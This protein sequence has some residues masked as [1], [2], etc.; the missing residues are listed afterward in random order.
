VLYC[1]L[2]HLFPY[3]NRLL[4]IL[5]YQPGPVSPSSQAQGS[6]SDNAD[7]IDPSAL[8]RQKQYILFYLLLDVEHLAD[9][10]S[11]ADVAN[12]FGAHFGVPISVQ[13]VL[14]S[15]WALDHSGSAGEL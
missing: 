4:S 8:A 1:S 13:R 7:E 14:R 3:E 10:P 9:H 15:L 5:Q 11:S 12:S 2:A 6:T